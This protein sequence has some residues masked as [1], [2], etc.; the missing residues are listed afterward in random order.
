MSTATLRT[1][2]FPE[3]GPGG[4]RFVVDCRHGTTTVDQ[5][6]PDNHDPVLTDRHLIAYAVARHELEEGC[7][8]AR[9][10]DTLARSGR[11]A[12]A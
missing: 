10:L 6:V 3:L 1:K 5:Y 9:G 4:R 2:S 11:G 12:R 7:G 8:C